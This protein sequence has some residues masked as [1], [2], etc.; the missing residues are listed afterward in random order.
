MARDVIYKFALRT[1]LICDVTDTECQ[2]QNGTLMI[3]SSRL[4]FSSSFT[5]ILKTA[6]ETSTS[7]DRDHLDVSLLRGQSSTS[8]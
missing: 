4:F 2:A 7:L 1:D 3:V 5:K 8:C 6:S